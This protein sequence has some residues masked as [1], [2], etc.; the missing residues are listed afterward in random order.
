MIKNIKNIKFN[1]IRLVEILFYTFPLWFI[2]GNFAVS[3]NTLLFIVVSLFLIQKKQL[4]LRFDNSCW[5]LIIFFLYFFISTTIQYQNNINN[6][7]ELVEAN[8][9]FAFNEKIESWP[10]EGHPI[11]KSFLLIRFVILI[12]V[13]DTL[14]FNK[15]LNFK[16]L[17]LVSFLCTSFV[18]FDIIFQ[19]IVGFDL[20]GLESF[21]VHN[22][23]PF[24]DEMIAGGYLQKL[25]FLSI[26]YFIE[27]AKNKNFNKS[28]VIF[29]ITLHTTGILLSGNRM[30]MILFLFGVK[31]YFEYCQSSAVSCRAPPRIARR[32]TIRQN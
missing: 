25:S 21:G 10:F 15:I 1:E 19:Y 30:P 5:L 17:F 6:F 9:E 16:K 22:S 12:L 28:L 31:M 3:L 18:S 23:G 4:A 20:F 13:I 7:N 14:F 26:F 8:K 27:I 32:F 2:I 11:L 29:I 24:G